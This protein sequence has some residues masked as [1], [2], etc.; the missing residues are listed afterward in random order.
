M[1]LTKIN[2][3]GFSHVVLPILAVVAIGAIG[4]IVLGASHA[5]SLPKYV[6]YSWN[7]SVYSVVPDSTPNSTFRSGDNGL[8]S[9]YVTG[10]MYKKTPAPISTVGY[11]PGSLVLRY[12]T[13]QAE[14]FMQA[15]STCTSTGTSSSCA[16]G[17]VHKLTLAEWKA[18][19]KAP[20]TQGMG[21]YKTA[22]NAT[23]FVVHPCSQHNPAAPDDLNGWK[24]Q[25]YPTP[26]IVSKIPSCY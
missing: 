19:G 24:L 22:S 17:L 9:L 12:Y 25:G 16:E 23:I 3:I 1:K 11:I 7:P 20:Q 8:A 6:K 4:T 26:Q 10:A 5:A 18:S 2:Q 14:L 15:P 13:T 21:V